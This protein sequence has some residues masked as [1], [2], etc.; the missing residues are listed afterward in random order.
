MKKGALETKPPDHNASGG[1][2]GG[3][4][5]KTLHFPYRGYGLDPPGQGTKIL[6]AVW[7]WLKTKT[8]NPQ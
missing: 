8:K 2:P 4:A 1:L 5:V 3:P 6:H 7:Q